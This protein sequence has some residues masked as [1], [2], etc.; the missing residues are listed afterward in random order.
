MRS[1][2]TFTTSS[3]TTTLFSLFSKALELLIAA[4]LVRGEF[5][6]FMRV[7]E[8]LIELLPE[9]APAPETHTDYLS[10]VARGRKVSLNRA[11]LDS[12]SPA[13][14][15][16]SEREQ[17]PPPPLLHLHPWLTQVAAECSMSIPSHTLAQPVPPQLAIDVIVAWLSHGLLGGI[18]KSLLAIL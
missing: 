16:S 1:L 2:T 14:A 4:H 9:H 6:D 15:R 18:R 17:A 3:T 13:S 12:H 5:A 11:P 10:N 7:L 8:L